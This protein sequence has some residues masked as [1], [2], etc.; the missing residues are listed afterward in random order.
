[1]RAEAEAVSARKGGRRPSPAL[2]RIGPCHDPLELWFLEWRTPEGQIFRRY[3]GEQDEAAAALA[4]WPA[5]PDLFAADP[6]KDTPRAR[7]DRGEARRVPPKP[8]QPKA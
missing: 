8:K 4:T 7:R 2:P 5:Q 6:L 1:V 3:F